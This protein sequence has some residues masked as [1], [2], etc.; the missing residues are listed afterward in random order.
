MIALAASILISFYLPKLLSYSGVLGADED[1]HVYEMAGV[2]KGWVDKFEKPWPC[3]NCG[4]SD[5]P[6]MRYHVRLHFLY[7]LDFSLLQDK[8]PGP[9][10]NME[11]LSKA[12]QEAIIHIDIIH[13]DVCYC[14]ACQTF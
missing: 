8:R 4:G 7:Y 10:M 5:F 3:D 12:L 13:I 11:D 2:Q 14:H 6:M 9:V 1:V